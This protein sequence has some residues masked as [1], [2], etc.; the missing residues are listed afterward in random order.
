MTQLET[1]ASAVKAKFSD[2]SFDEQCSKYYFAAFDATVKYGLLVLVKEPDPVNYSVI[3]TANGIDS[4]GYDST[5]LLNGTE[6]GTCT[7]SDLYIKTVTTRDTI[8][9]SAG[10]NWRNNIYSLSG[11]TVANRLKNGT[12]LT[13]EQMTQLETTSRAGKAKFS[14]LSFDEQCS[15]YYFAAFDATAKYG[16]L[17]QVK[18]SATTIDT[19]ALE[20]EI[21]KVWDGSDYTDKYYTNTDRWNGKKSYTKD[22]NN[23]E[24]GSFWDATEKDGNPLATALGDFSSQTKV[25]EAVEALSSV[26]SDLIPSDQANATLLY[27]ALQTHWVWDLTRVREFW[28]NT[29]YEDISASNT[30]TVTWQPYAAALS[31]GQALLDSLYDA[32]GNATK[33]NKA[34]L[35]T[36]IAELVDALDVSKLVN[37]AFY[38]EW[39]NNFQSRRSAAEALLAQ[40]DPSNLD[41]AAYTS[42]SWSALETAWSKLNDDLNYRIEGGSSA[43]M[44][45]LLA[46]STHYD[47]LQSAYQGLVSDTDITV[48][49]TYVNNF[50]AKYPALRSAGQDILQVDALP[51]ENGQTTVQD[52]VTAAYVQFD[53]VDIRGFV[54]PG[55]INN[56]SDTSPVYLVY[57]NGKYMGNSTQ[58]I[59]LHDNDDVRVVRICK[60]VNVTEVSTGQSGSSNL[61]NPTLDT[62]YLG[63][64]LAMITMTAPEAPKVGD[65]AEFSATLTG[66]YGSSVGEAFNA[67][68]ITLF[69]SEPYADEAEHFTYQPT[70]NTGVSTDASGK[71]E[72][73]FS[74][75]GWYAVAMFN[76]EDDTPTFTDIYDS[77][78]DGVYPS[79]YAGDFSFVYVAPSED[80]AK[81]IAQ[82]KAEYAETAK[83]YF[84]GFHDYDFADG[85]YAETFKPQYD[86]LVEH[87]EG[88]LSYKALKEQFEADFALLKEYG[89]T[90]IDHQGLVDALREKLGY[91]PENL[92]E[93]N[94][95]HAALVTEIQ[96]AYAAM[97][98]HTK[99]LLTQAELDRLE[100][101]AAIDVSALPTVS[102]VTVQIQTIGS[103][104]FRSGNGNPYYGYPNL[105]WVKTPNPDGTIDNPVW[106]TTYDTSILNAKAGDHVFV[107]KYLD[108]TDAQYRMVWSVDGGTTWTS[109]QPQ[110]LVDLGGN[111]SYDGYYLVEYIVPK[112][113]A[114]GSTVTIQLKMWSKA[115]YDANGIESTKSDALAALQAAYD[116]YDL[117]QYNDAG[118]AALAQALE[119]GKAA[120]NAETTIDGV[121][122]ARKAAI[123]AMAAVPVAEGQHTE[124]SYDSGTTVGR[125]FVT[126]ENTT[127]SDMMYGTIAEGWYELGDKDTMMTVVLK[128][129]E[130]EGF[131][132]NG[133]G[134]GSGAYDYTITYLAGITKDGQTL[135][136]FTGGKK[137]G[138]MGTLNDWFVNESFSMFSV[139]NGKLENNDVIRVVYTME[140][141]TDVG[142]VWGV[143]D[144]S[145]ASLSISAGT[146]S[147]AFDGGTTDYTLVL[148]D[149]VS[150]VTVKPIPVNK[151]YQSRIFL[152]SYNQDSAMFKRTDAI[153]VK[154]GDVIYVGVGEQGWP[155]MNNGGKPTKYTIKIAT[156][157]GAVEDLD[158]GKVNL[159]NYKTYAAKLAAIDY[160]SLSDAGKAKYDAV[161]ARVDFYQSVDDLKAEIEALPSNIT[162]ADKTA[163]NAA[164]AHYNDLTE[165][166][167]LLTGAEINKLFKADNTIKLLT[168]M[169][170]ITS[171]KNFDHTEANTSGEVKSALET[172]LSG[173]GLGSDVTVSV[174]VKPFT[175]ASSSADG[176]YS[177]TVTLSIGEGGRM[178]SGEKNVTGT[179]KYIKSNDADVESIRANGVPATGSGTSRSAVLPFG[180]NL[181]S[182]NFEIET[183][184]SK[185]KVT[186]PPATSDGGT[187]WTFTVTAEDGESKLA[188]TVTLTVNPVKVKAA[189]S[190]AYSINAD[191]EPIEVNGLVE[192]ISTDKLNLPDGT[193]NVSVWVEATKT[194]GSGKDVTVTVA[195]KY[196][197]DG[198]A[199]ADIPAAA[200]LGDFRVTL[201]V[202][203]TEYARVLSGEDYLEAEADAN[204]FSFDARSG[205]Y[206]LIS[207]A[208]IAAVTYHLNGGTASGLTDSQQ[209]I[210]FRADSGTALPTPTRSG[211]TFK[212]W[213]GNSSGSGTK[214]TA[215]NAQ[216]PGELY[217]IW[218]SND[219]GATVTVC[220]TEATK[221]GV[222]FSVELPYNSAYPKAS[223]ITVTPADGA[224]AT[225]PMTGDDGASWSF[226]VTAEDGTARAYTLQIE[227]AEQTAVEK[228]AEAK[229]AIEDAEWTVAQTTANDAD[230]LK[231]F[232]EGKLA[233][234]GLNVSYE[235]TVTDV[236]PAAAGTKENE[237]GT[238]GSYGFTAALTLGEETA[239]A[240]FTNAAITAN[241]YEA[242]TAYKAALDAVLPYIKDTTPNPTVG[243]TG[244]EWIVFALNRGGVNDENWNNKYLAKLQAYVDNCDGKLHDR[245]YTEYSRVVLALTSMGYDA[246]QFQAGEK[247]YDLVTPLLDKQDNGAYWA[248]W[249]GNNGTAFALLALNSHNY[250]DNAEGNAAR[251]AFIA[252]L[253]ANQ[254]ENGAWPISEGDGSDLDVTAAAIYALAPYYLD[255]AKLDALGGSV[256]H[257]ELKAMVDKALTFLSNVQD[258]AGGYGSVEADGWVIIALS[259]LKRDAD[260]DEAF[261]KNGVS[262]LADFLGYFD[263]NTGGFRHLAGGDVNQMSSEQA[264]YDLV[265]Y[266]RFKTG[267][268][269]LYDMSDVTFPDPETPPVAVTG[270]TLDQTTASVEEGKSVTLTATVEPGNATNKLVVWTSGDE[271][272]ATVTNGVVTGVKAGTVTITATA[273]G[274]SASCAVTVTK[275][276]GGSG[277]GAR[278]INVSFRLI[279]AEKAKQDVD[280]GKDSYLPNYVT[281]IPTTSY[282]LDEG[283]TVYDLWVTATGEAGIRS[284]GAENNYVETVYAPDG[285]A[286]SE[287]TNGPRSG[288][289]Y[290][291]NGSHPGFGLVEQELHDGDEVIWHYVNDY[292]YEVADWFGGD[293]RWPSLGDGTYYNGWLNAPDRTGS[294]GGGS[295][296]GGGASGI[297]NVVAPTT[298]GKATLDPE[299]AEKD[300][301]VTVRVQPD[302]GYELDAITAKDADGN[303]V[304]LT[305][306]ADG[307]YSFVQPETGVTVTVTFKQKEK[308]DSVEI[309]EG[310]ITA[311][312]EVADGAA[313]AEFTA[314]NVAEA[315]K[316][317]DKTETLSVK[318]ETED[319]KRVE[320]ALPAEAVK[321]V[322]DAD[323][324]LSVETENGA[325][326]ID[327]DTLKSAA[328]KDLTVAV[329]ANEDGSTTF[330]MTAGGETVDAKLKVELPAEDG[331]VLVI[332]NEDGSEELVKKSVVEDG[333]AYAEIPAGATVKVIDNDKEFVDVADNAWYAEAVEFA[334]SH[335]L[336][337]GVG[338]DKFAPAAPMTRAMLATVLYRLEDA[339][340]TGTN[341]FD[342]VADGTWYTDA[343]TWANE[344][345]IVMGTGKGFDPNANITREQIATMLYR[346]AKYLGLD[347]SGSAALDQFSDG[348]E[349]ASWAKDAMQWAVSAGLF[350]GDDNGALNPK[351]DA[352]RAEVATLF[353]RMIK[354]I[355]K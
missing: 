304:A 326:K 334:S 9:V 159:Q 149:G 306:N 70:T 74:E 65:K 107:R 274:K 179:I 311:R 321:T 161:K 206:T 345:G 222:V 257:A 84:E 189:Q 253:K 227:F 160:N 56:T 316:D 336:F 66:A 277:S 282:E 269:A 210:Y 72:Y 100:Q 34:S 10:E 187:T 89:A 60:P 150:S 350:R 17:I 226:T 106:A 77:T 233:T 305:K 148:P 139:A 250:L 349:T 232:V 59:Q 330:D 129:L 241:A 1:T 271:S 165:A 207:D 127:Y 99:T 331:Q 36:R 344:E 256:S 16:L 98:E 44:E 20:A 338:D 115:E 184:D 175:A 185:A 156:A 264:A 219:A 178:A 238:D 32:K 255:S 268:N 339:V 270:I 246:T 125:V 196:S 80:E 213:Y 313:K 120:V 48:D 21:E 276:S 252:S 242:P 42:D 258:S 248:E 205:Q 38:T 341:P 111:G 118:K 261:V 216:L 310:E 199:A 324:A 307:T 22:E 131:T 5:V 8:T 51:L 348:S 328:D 260:T 82:Y 166:H 27:E 68:N 266:D 45:M 151:N 280:L 340:A 144:T 7:L 33:D 137:S 319:A 55:D 352:T 237:T 333:K 218:Q 245:K 79:V 332:V 327:A 104:P 153:P 320:A 126:I 183:R 28:G 170:K 200:I 90:A 119:D 288:W 329:K 63:D 295:A 259:A 37:K 123:A 83:A 102:A 2:L 140:K 4:N 174:D 47:A 105:A 347:V 112:D 299:I 223:D 93:L 91:L 19:S 167:D 39:Y 97:G 52:A 353:E 152:N 221:S 251:A 73:V 239:T 18:G 193:E 308:S 162:T 177:A 228:L 122:A 302:K 86:T 88:A 190:S 146:L 285:Y 346:Y 298:H 243:S 354:L 236:T 292:S 296:A 283:A 220:G 30:T 117:T 13:D 198:G 3:F 109:S 293:D 208:H 300:E 43:D 164:M 297:E 240:T 135:A 26:I 142:S 58:T 180:S 204:G 173:L 203:G 134:G 351:G 132:W 186:A 62:V 85:Y 157:D 54:I 247:T 217:A 230:A 69:V 12:A 212:G 262:V 136:E 145:L 124:G 254:T 40:S 116:A 169:D 335:D 50:A 141:G 202:S 263:E 6:I 76:V 23:P 279:G 147:P 290:T 275:A 355:V 322:A 287:F 342:D 272:I 154:V 155:T 49:F 215:V 281:W 143:N 61:E 176:S 133:T 53:S 191:V 309:A 96:A 172:W 113:V 244:G 171:P 337:K 301:T 57:V 278:T 201:P 312:P 194:G 211:F 78:T 234:M 163:V 15:K 229:K 294:K 303:T 31:E 95:S 64:S 101:I 121:A 87:L 273:G 235:V 267:K 314:E 94:S 11:T 81:L 325:V 110:T 318:V 130:D 317:A 29:A 138:W 114:D 182:V 323:K 289:M 224:V 225:K 214:Y 14:D 195:A 46:F 286:L 108:S 265:A 71:L 75:P 67:G 158:A 92:A 284:V 291:I 209:S 231:T 41:S 197:V 315:L 188:Y 103:L 343:V 181:A 24:R 35:N 192:A 249:Q 128:V 25:D 168:A